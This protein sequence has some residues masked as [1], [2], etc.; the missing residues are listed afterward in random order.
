MKTERRRHNKKK[1]YKNS[2][3]LI[4]KLAVNPEGVDWEI[5]LILLHAFYTKNRV[6]RKSETLEKKIFI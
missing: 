2:E 4:W 1:I 6:E 5:A 3:A